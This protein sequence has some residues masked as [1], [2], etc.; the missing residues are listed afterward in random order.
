MELRKYKRIVNKS[1]PKYALGKPDDV[2]IEEW[3]NN[4]IQ[5]INRQQLLQKLEDLRSEN[6]N[7]INAKAANDIMQS[8]QAGTGLL[9]NIINQTKATSTD[10]LAN[11]SNNGSGSIMGINYDKTEDLDRSAI[12]KEQKKGIFGGVLSGMASGA[13]TGAAAGGIGAAIG[14]AAGGLFSGIGSIF[15]RN[16]LK[17]NITAAQEKITNKNMFNRTSAMSQALA[18]QYS[19]KN[20]N[21][22]GQ[23]LYGYKY[24][25]DSV[26]TS[27][28]SSNE[29]QNSWVSE[30]E[31]IYNIKNGDAHLVDHGPNDTAKANTKP[32]DVVFGEQINPKT[33]MT[34][35]DEAAPY[36]KAKEELNKKRPKS[37]GWLTK[38]TEDLY[39]QESAKLANPIDEKL[40][41]LAEEQKVVNQLQNE[42]IYPRYKDGKIAWS[43]N[44]IPSLLGIGTALGQYFDASRQR[45]YKP[46]TYVPNR[47]E[48]QA[49]QTLSE[50]R[51]NPYP[52]INQMRDAEG[53]LNYDI[54]NSGGLSNAQKYLQRVAAATNTQNTI[55][56]LLFKSRE[57]D[58]KYKEDYAARLLDAGAQSAQRRQAAIQSDND[59]YAKAHAARLQGK[60]IGIY[61]FLN[62]VNQYAANEFKRKSSNYMHGLYSQQLSTDQLA[63]LMQ[64]QNMNRGTVTIPPQIEQPKRDDFPYIYDWGKKEDYNYPETINPYI[65]NNYQIKPWQ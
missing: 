8:V 29:P 36:I 63:L 41:G 5:Q 45:I 31:G 64:L 51:T 10:Q 46:N 6:R 33:G 54:N 55:A 25:K 44:G 65:W 39:E 50:L 38:N 61:N 47:Y 19:T 1:Y 13:A 35:K 49:L 37:Y 2:N 42:M 59:M 21:T 57:Q 15:G 7:T 14:A 9:T 58:N 11:E 28:G 40:K 43:S 52:I 27:Y 53:K 22:E 24:G 30:G 4:I 32:E 17:K 26:E 3:N 23:M 16:R 20:G 18:S 62:N 48:Q 60:Q 56:D 12:L 34:F